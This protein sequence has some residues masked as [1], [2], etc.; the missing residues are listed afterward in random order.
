MEKTIEL[1]R[2]RLQ[3]QSLLKTKQEQQD[4]MDLLTS[5]K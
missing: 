2:L 1:E 5:S 3:Y 4:Y